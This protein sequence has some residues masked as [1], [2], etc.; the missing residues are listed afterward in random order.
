MTEDQPP[1]KHEPHPVPY[2]DVSQLHPLGEDFVSVVHYPK[3]VFPYKWIVYGGNYWDTVLKVIKPRG[4][5]LVKTK[6]EETLNQI[7]LIWKPVPFSHSVRVE[8]NLVL[9]Q[10]R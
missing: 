2:K 4:F 6:D 3:S 9:C 1:S 8:L 7:D 10:N 5:T